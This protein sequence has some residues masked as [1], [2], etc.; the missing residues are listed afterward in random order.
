MRVSSSDSPPAHKI[1]SMPTGRLI[2]LVPPASD[3]GITTQ[4]I[5]E[6]AIATGGRIQLLSL[7]KDIANKPSLHRQLVLMSALMGHSRISTE[8]K[9]E[10]GTNWVDAVKRNYQTGDIIVCFAEQC[11]GFL[12]KPLSQILEE[13]LDTPILILGG[14]YHEQPS[15]LNPL[16]RTAFWIGVIS[17]ITAAFFLQIW[18]MSLPRDWSQTTLLI[19]AVITELWLIW[20]WNQLFS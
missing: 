16:S 7:C 9:V 8:A 3:Y 14:H 12:R 17:I 6:L 20:V 13:N 15:R 2:V 19:L 4:R 10:M 1:G 11:D 18:I 5:W